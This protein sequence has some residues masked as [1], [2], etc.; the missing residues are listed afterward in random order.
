M[1]ILCVIGA[2][3]GSQGLPGKNVRP[4]LGKPLIAWSIEQALAVPE[5]DRIVVSTDSEEIAAAAA[6]AGVEAP[7]LRPDDLSGPM[8]GK[9]QVWQ[10]ALAAC[11]AHYGETYEAVVDL[12]CT[13]PLREP[14]DI[15][16]AIAQFRAGRERGVDAVFSTCEARKN[17]YFNLVEPDAAGALKMSKSLGDTVVARQAAPPVF[18]HVASLYVL[19]PDYLRRANHLLDGHAEGYDIGQEKSFDVDSEFDFR[20]VEMLM[21]LRTTDNET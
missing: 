5:V 11:E 20:I 8:V 12:D 2:R 6:V 16:A 14:A 15:S 4:L 10:H 19:A 1:T 13:N 3:G 17:P 7:F 9:F 21:N 18:E